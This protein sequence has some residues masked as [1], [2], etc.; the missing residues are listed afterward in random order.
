MTWDW[1]ELAAMVVTAIL[2]W[3]ARHLT[4]PKSKE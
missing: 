2:G 4:I 3:F 1:E